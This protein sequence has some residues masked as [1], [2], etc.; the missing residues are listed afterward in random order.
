MS[1]AIDSSLFPL[2]TNRL[3]KGNRRLLRI[4]II[5]ILCASQFGEIQWREVFDHIFYREFIFDTPESESE[6]IL[7]PSEVIEL[8]SD[9]KIQWEEDDIRFASRLL[10]AIDLNKKVLHAYVDSVSENWSV[11]RISS[12]DLMILFLGIVEII[13]FKEIPPKATLNEAIEIAKS[14]SSTKSTTFINGILDFTNSQY[15]ALVATKKD[16]YSDVENFILTIM[17]SLD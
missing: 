4:K 16:E 15:E 8:D 1:K 10:Y 5:Q 9:S 2:S 11:E 6:K 3:I 12:L 14:L 7:K 13:L 17:K